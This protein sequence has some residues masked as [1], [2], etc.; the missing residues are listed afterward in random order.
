MSQSFVESLG[1][2]PKSRNLAMTLAR[3]YDQATAYSH[4]VVM[5][6]HVLL[7]LIS[8]SDAS[9]VLQACQ[10][11]LNQLNADVTG[12]L[13]N[14]EDRA[15]PGTEPNPGPAPDVIRIL[16]YAAAAAQQSRRRDI[17]GAIV[18]AAI[19]GDG[20]SPAAG[21]LRAQGLTF[22]EAVKALQRASAAPRPAP[23][24]QP[25][26]APAPAP[27]ATPEPPPP[28]GEMPP[29][30]H[31]ASHPAP[32]WPGQQG[33]ELPRHVNG[34][35]PNSATEEILAR[36]RRRVETGRRPDH[37]EHESEAPA[38]PV[39]PAQ[40]EPNPYD[41]PHEPY[42]TQAAEPPP[43]NGVPIEPY[44]SYGDDYAHHEPEHPIP[45]PDSMA[46]EQPPPMMP[47]PPDNPT[48][49]SSRWGMRP[50]APR[51]QPT[52]H[53]HVGF[54]R[55]QPPPA[56]HRG[57]PPRSAPPP[58]SSPQAEANAAQAPPPGAQRRGR[59]PAD[60]RNNTA[61]AAGQLVENIP[62]SMRVGHSVTVEAR[63]A[64]ADV[65]ALAEGLQGS[66]TA[67]RHDLVVTKAMSVRLRAPDGGFW[68]ETA[69]PETQWIENSLGPLS[70][71]F[72]SWR[73]TVT[74]QRSGKARLQLVVSA[75]T[76]G[77]DGL[78]A[79]TALPDRY[80]N[81][82]VRI[83]Y[84]RTFSHWGGWIVAAMIGGVLAKFGENVWNFVQ[85][86]IGGY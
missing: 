8:D 84:G 66:G 64:K 62:R 12:Y 73:W 79:E 18:L 80:I 3:A 63:I 77:T 56:P 21:M 75:R 25:A 53:P 55:P 69:S 70:D 67:Y 45:Q 37:P 23:Q 43:I 85:S 33:G 86:I 19:V 1:W 7:A 49:A 5:L 16:E 15:P 40:P 39:P 38:A 68:I 29:A 42:P 34:G 26:A 65:T 81:V 35:L 71:D 61:V 4:R 47:P 48:P 57:E 54:P 58:W 74:P 17:N 60:A 11:D 28:R 31:P 13:S 27:I 32:D 30:P 6:E 24:P 82:K 36:A 72:A 22:E 46:P 52:I 20:R 83:N 78:A 59:A 10:V 44:P 50:L 14:V 2:V 76:I 51:S 9:A 41:P